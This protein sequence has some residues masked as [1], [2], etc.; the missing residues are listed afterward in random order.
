MQSAHC[1]TK[2]KNI[3]IE[4]DGVVIE[5]LEPG[6]LTAYVASD[7]IN[8]EVIKAIEKAGYR[9]NAETEGSSSNCSTGCCN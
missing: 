8:D 4:M 7:K 6:K 5:N 9:I 1:Q 3:L 2:V